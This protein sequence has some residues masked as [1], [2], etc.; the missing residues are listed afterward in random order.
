ME[1]HGGKAEREDPANGVLMEAGHRGGSAWQGE[2]LC[3]TQRE[4]DG[5]R[6]DPS[7]QEGLGMA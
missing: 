3:A 2:T 1:A 4:R 6:A 5:H 7:L